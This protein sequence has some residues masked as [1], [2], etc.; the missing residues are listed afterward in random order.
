[1]ST[2]EQR[3]STAARQSQ[4]DAA[5]GFGT[6]HCWA[7]R[8]KSSSPPWLWFCSDSFLESTPAPP[9]T[10]TYK[11]STSMCCCYCSNSNHNTNT[12]VTPLDSSA[13]WQQTHQLSPR[14]SAL[15]IMKKKQKPK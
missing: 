11:A 13:D 2:R 7:Q 6:R 8:A 14:W 3:S 9:S 15:A 5:P 12:D 10:R 1:M 4:F